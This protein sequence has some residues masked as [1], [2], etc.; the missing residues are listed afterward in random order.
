MKLKHIGALSAVLLLA[1]CGNKAKTMNTATIVAAPNATGSMS[2]NPKEA[3]LVA[4]V[5]DRV[6]FAVNSSTLS[7]ADQNVLNKQATW[8]KANPSVNVLIAGNCDNR[9]TPQYNLALGWRR[10][11]AAR[12]FLV[13]AGV[14][15]S[16]IT[17]VS[18]GSMRPIALGANS[19]AWAQNRAA[20]TSVVGANPQMQPSN[21]QMQSSNSSA[22]N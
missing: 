11:M 13:A 6:Y 18:Y 22:S 19:Q 9:G 15:P 7:P 16:Q 3:Y 8:L 12:N 4:N 20:I 14:A 21:A 17:T 5:G 10:A 2:S 1:A